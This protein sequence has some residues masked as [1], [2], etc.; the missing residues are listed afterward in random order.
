MSKIRLSDLIIT[1]VCSA[2]TLYT[3]A[4]ARLKKND[5][6]RWAVVMKY[7]GETV[8]TFDGKQLVSDCEHVVILPKGCSYEWHCTKAGHFSIIEF[9]CPATW[10]EPVAFPVKHGDHILQ[11][12]RGLEF[13]RNRKTPTTEMES[14]RDLYS[15][16]LQ[17]A[18]AS[19]YLPTKKQ[20]RVAPAVE[21]ISQ[22]YT[23]PITNREL[24]ALTGLSTV[25]FRKL[26]TEVMGTSPMVYARRLRI[27]KA[28]ELLQSDYGTLTDLAQSL[29]YASLY[30]FSRDFKKHT[31]TAPSHY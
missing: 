31:G 8:Y 30:D 7:E 6:A 9:E 10:P 15:I 14:I 4:N 3:P 5:R 28:R 19:E 16:L 26:F 25:Y 11:L 22:N 27:E 1:K 23:K 12:F 18:R 29:G 13:A 17:A 2:S 24:A 21:Y 20:E